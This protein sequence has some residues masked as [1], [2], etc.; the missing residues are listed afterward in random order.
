MVYQCKY[1]PRLTSGKCP[2]MTQTKTRKLRTCKYGERVANGTC[3]K[4]NQHKS[5][6]SVNKKKLNNH[7]PK[8]AS[9]PKSPLITNSNMSSITN[10][11]VD[12]EAELK[13][14]GLNINTNVIVKCD[15]YDCMTGVFEFTNP[16]HKVS[17]GKD[18]PTNR[19]VVF[20]FDIY[21]DA[22]YDNGK[23]KNEILY[24]RKGRSGIIPLIPVYFTSM[25]KMNKFIRQNKDTM[26]AQYGKLGTDYF[27]T[28]L[29]LAN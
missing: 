2:K 27:C 18:R 13:A 25:N 11:N 20:T 21:E 17:H 14:A 16:A 1:G 24:L 6:I 7:K 15:M 28:S 23:I 19:P 4:K 8:P 22:I 26:I 10:S 12:F 3:P 9:S 5:N 29:Y